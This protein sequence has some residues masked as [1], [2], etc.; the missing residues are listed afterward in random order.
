MTRPSSPARVLVW[1][2]N[3]HEQIEE[4]VRAIY[5]DGM[6][7]TIAEG[8]RTNLGE[9]ATVSTTTLDE[10]EHGLTEEVLDATDVLVWW[11]HMAHGDVTD[12][13]VERVQRHV[14]SGMGLVVLHSGHWSKIFGKLM[15]TT[16]TLRWRSEQDRELVWT[17]DP[18]HPIAQGVPHPFVIPQQEMYGEFFD[19]PAPD[20]L[21]FLSTF[22]GGEVFRSGM[23]WKRGHGRIF[24]FSPGDQDYPVY[25]QEEVR[26]VIANG[27]EW[28]RSSRPDRR[29]PVLRRYR[30][31][32]FHNGEDYEGALVR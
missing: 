19:V 27:V 29:L 20:E 31:E 24:F 26:R 16:C 9:H 15:G 12:E 3:R 5:P 21:V 14:L 17:V 7:T 32:D 18:T 10:P 11:G 4:K 25:H 13:I 8:I 23:T 6:H 22:S 30:T 28:A 1:G 2:E